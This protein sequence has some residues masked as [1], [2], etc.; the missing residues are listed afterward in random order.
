M[1]LSPS[2]LLPQDFFAE[3]SQASLTCAITGPVTFKNME[4]VAG[5]EGQEIFAERKNLFNILQNKVEAPCWLWLATGG[6]AQRSLP[7]HGRGRPKLGGWVAWGTSQA[8][9]ATRSLVRLRS[10]LQSLHSLQPLACPLALP[11][12]AAGAAGVRPKEQHPHLCGLL[13]ALHLRHGAASMLRTLPGD[14][15]FVMVQ[16]LS[17]MSSRRARVP[18]LLCE[19]ARMLFSKDWGW[20]LPPKRTKSDTTKCGTCHPAG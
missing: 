3:P 12:D 4:K 15:W 9:L 19:G 6:L 14:L 10:H 16:L 18:C 5:S 1:A 17:R 13:H 20:R 7:D 8:A 2:S 11:A